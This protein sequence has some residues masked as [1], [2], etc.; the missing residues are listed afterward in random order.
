MLPLHVVDMSDDEKSI[1]D[2]G[3]E[4]DTERYSLRKD[5][6]PSRKKLEN[7]ALQLSE[8]LHIL[9]RKIRKLWVV[10]DESYEANETSLVTEK[11]LELET[12]N[13]QSK[14]LFTKFKVLKSYDSWGIFDSIEY[15]ALLIKE[16][17]IE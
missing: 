5:P 13:T 11:Q 9:I 3:E 16:P 14:E 2:E 6:P 8:A 12:L 17:Y 10:I 15:S 4:Y 7:D 1:H